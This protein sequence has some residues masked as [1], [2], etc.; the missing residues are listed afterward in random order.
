MDKKEGEESLV[1]IIE[2][3]Q[4]VWFEVLPANSFDPIFNVDAMI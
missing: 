4:R 3:M 2:V 1:A